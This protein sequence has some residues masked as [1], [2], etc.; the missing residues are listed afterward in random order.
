MP[1]SKPLIDADG[2]VREITRRDLKRIRPARKVVS[3]ALMA[4]AKRRRGR[5]KAPTKRQVSIRL[6]REVLAFFRRGG[7]G[8]Q[9]RIDATLRKAA[10]L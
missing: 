1:K 10:G 8:W 5:Q 9:T 7:R 4:A 2:E 3:P 6:S